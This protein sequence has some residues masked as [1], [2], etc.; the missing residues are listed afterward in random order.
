MYYPNLASLTFYLYYL[1][2]QGP[3]SGFIDLIISIVYVAYPDSDFNLKNGPT[4]VNLG[5]ELFHFM[6]F[7]EKVFYWILLVIAILTFNL[8]G[9]WVVISQYLLG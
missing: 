7:S 2:V 8:N 9:Y 6:E 4:R 3:L 5:E 1:Y